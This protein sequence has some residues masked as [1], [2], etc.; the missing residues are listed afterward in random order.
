MHSD[1]NLVFNRRPTADVLGVPASR[2]CVL[3][4]L[5]GELH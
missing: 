3:S 2:L 4:L 5:E 1:I